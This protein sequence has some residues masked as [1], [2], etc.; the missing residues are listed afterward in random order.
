MSSF[1]REPFRRFQFLALEF[2]HIFTGLDLC[3]SSVLRLSYTY[4]PSIVV[5]F[6]QL[7]FLFL[8]LWFYSFNVVLFLQLWLG[9]C[10]IINR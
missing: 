10:L 8:Q 6:L 2:Y 1:T 5:L 4:I 3:L 7:W 9:T